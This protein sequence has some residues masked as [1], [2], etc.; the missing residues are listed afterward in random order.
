MGKN[1][2][3]EGRERTLRIMDLKRILL[4]DIELNVVYKFHK[5]KNAKN[6]IL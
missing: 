3:K 5:K 1:G 4:L 2:K 6:G